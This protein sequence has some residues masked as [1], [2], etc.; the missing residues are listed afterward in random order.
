M[1]MK[2]YLSLEGANE[3][4]FSIIKIK[5]NVNLLNYTINLPKFLKNYDKKLINN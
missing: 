4:N 5:I 1:N 3:I 2:K